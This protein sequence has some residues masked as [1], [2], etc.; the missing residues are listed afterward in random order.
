VRFGLLGS[1]LV[2][3]EAGS[4]VDVGGAQ[5]RTI[6][7]LLVAAAGRVV[8]ADTLIDV[9]WGEEPPPSAAGTVQTYISRL[10]RALERGRRPGT[11][12]TVLVREPPGYRLGVT[13]DEVDF[14][15]FEQLADEGRTLLGAG[16]HAEAREILSVADGLWRGP[17]LVEFLDVEALAGVAARLEDRRLAA[18]EDRVAADLALGNHSAVVSDLSELVAAHPLREGLRAHLALALYRGG[19]QAEAL[20]CLDDTRI[21]LRDELGVELSRPLRDLEQA[22]LAHDA[23]LDGTGGAGGTGGLGATLMTDESVTTGKAMGEP[24]PVTP[25]AG[26]FVGRDAE[27]AEVRAAFAE[28]AGGVARVV[29]IEGDPGIGK[30]RLAE[31]LSVEAAAAGALV[32]WGRAFE[33]GAAPAFWPWLPPLRALVEACPPASGPLPAEL[34]VLVAPADPQESPAPVAELARFSLFE[35]VVALLVDQARRQPVVLVLDD[36]QWADVASLELLAATVARLP[37]AAVLIAVTVRELEVGRRDAVVDTLADLSRRLG[38]RRLRLRGLSDTGTEALVAQTA[39]VVVDATTAAAIHAR[40]EGNPFFTTELARLV[41]GGDELPSSDVPSGVRDVVRQRLAHLPAET[42]DLLGVAAVIGRD[43]DLGLVS[44]AAGNELDESLDALEPALVQRLLVADPDQ[45]GQLR[46]AHALVREVLVEDLSP[47][48][49]ARLHLRVADALDERDDL[50]EIVAEH[51]WNAVAIGVGARAAEALERASHVAARRMAYDSARGMLERAVQLRRATG[52]SAPE[53][54]EAEL[55]TVVRLVAVIGVAGG[56]TAVLG[57]PLIA[58]GKALAEQT[59][60]TREL[61]N[62]LWAEWAGMDV[63]CLTAQADPIARDLLAMAEAVPTPAAPVM[64]HTAYAISCWHRGAITES[65]HHFDIAAAGVGTLVPDAG[66]D[67]LLSFNQLWLSVPFRAYVHALAGDLDEPEA[68]FD[69]IVRQAPGFPYW[70]LL[71]MNFAASCAVSTGDLSRAERAA[72]RGLAADPDGIVKFWG[73]AAALYLGAARCLQGDLDEG[74]PLL[75]DAWAR[76]TATGQR[77]NGVTVL[78][79]RAQGLAAAGRVEQAAGALDA[80]RRELEI[81]GEHFAEPALLIAEAT[82][83]H[84]RGDR[85]PTM[86]ALDRAMAIATAQGAHG[87][88]RRVQTVAVDLGFG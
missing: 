56:Y 30:T 62:L 29:V 2:V 46:F 54:R 63:A 14:R 71:V 84:A 86:G 1:L 72:R 3:D 85:D 88:G 27:L 52:G 35:A 7:A 19:R 32:R 69:E 78:A 31:E 24:L 40:A 11:P 10:R 39:G 64:G 21:V 50:A 26:G 82:L 8:T 47:L 20:R 28:A 81:Y 13:A 42:L 45:Y 66:G 36:L 33:G 15:R 23:R 37:D 18:V 25:V 48:R 74:L 49:R 77:T 34:A 16:R 68:A 73:V 9:L 38:T 43:L 12:A 59:G 44:L 4:S 57:S 67:P 6:L 80:G 53:A 87:V 76:Y 5:P 58:R 41:A 61:F 75:D 55:A 65:A 22:I 60:R 79:A 51:L 83:H 70:E 17:A